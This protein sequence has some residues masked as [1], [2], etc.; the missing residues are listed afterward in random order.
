MVPSI[1]HPRYDPYARRWV[2][3]PGSYTLYAQD[4]AGSMWDGFLQDV[5]PIPNPPVAAAADGAGA[6][7]GRGGSGGVKG[8]VGS[9]GVPTWQ[10]VGCTVMGSAKLTIERPPQ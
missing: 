9:P 10:G 2:L 1:C 8:A 4:C 5:K 6:D 3:D 7:G